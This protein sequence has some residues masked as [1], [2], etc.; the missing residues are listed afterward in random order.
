MSEIAGK[1]RKRC[2]DYPKGKYKPTCIIHDPVYYSDECKVLG[3]F[4]SKY[5]KNMPTKDRRNNNVLRKKFNRQQ[6]NNTIV[7]IVVDEPPCMKT[8]SI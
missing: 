4:G 8:K 2:L 1:C 6:D 7:N 3:N 5:A